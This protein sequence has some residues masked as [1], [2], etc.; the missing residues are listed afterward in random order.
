MESTSDEQ[1][2]MINEPLLKKTPKGG[3]RTMPFIIANEAFE[4]VASYGLTPNMILYLMREYHMEMAT[5]SNILFLWSAA[6]NFLPV[7]GALLADSLMG[8][9]WM[10]AFGSVISFLV[11][12]PL[13]NFI[14]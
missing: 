9:F 13:Q 2:M 4:K 11:K 7:V 1:K 12:F 5:G 10:I 3:F 14:V 6:T 8:R